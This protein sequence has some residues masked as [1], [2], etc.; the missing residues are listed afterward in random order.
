MIRD[1]R[2]RN[3]VLAILSGTGNENAI[4]HILHYTL[5]Q[6]VISNIYYIVLEIYV[7]P[8]KRNI[9]H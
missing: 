4:V 3:G 6:V 1:L 2:F 8:M 5:V 9:C 7:F